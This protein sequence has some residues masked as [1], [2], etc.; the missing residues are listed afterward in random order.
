MQNVSDSPLSFPK[1]PKL[2]SQAVFPAFGE[3]SHL[4]VSGYLELWLDF[5]LWHYP[6]SKEVKN[7]QGNK[8]SPFNISSASL[9][10]TAPQTTL[11]RYLKQ[12]L[13]SG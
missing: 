11:H 4:V 5:L 12:F 13:R 2:F 7:P 3:E 9:S 10:E 8:E 1:A 6:Q